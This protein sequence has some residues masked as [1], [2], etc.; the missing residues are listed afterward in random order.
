[1]ESGMH[2]LRSPLLVIVAMVLIVGCT[3][4]DEHMSDETL[5]TAFLK[6][7]ADFEQLRRMVTAGR[8]LLR[9]DAYREANE[10][11]QVAMRTKRH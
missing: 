7:Q 8:K 6:H 4:H 11:I 1:M 10:Q 9:V 5:I 2:H 3:R